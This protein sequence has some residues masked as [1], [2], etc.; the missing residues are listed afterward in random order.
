MQTTPKTA[1][2]APTKRANRNRI[3][4]I[5]RILFQKLSQ[6]DERA[7][8]LNTCARAHPD[9]FGGTY[10][11]EL[12]QV[13]ALDDPVAPGNAYAVQRIAELRYQLLL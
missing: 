11:R 4:G 6:G 12:L 9:R 3:I 13:F 10:G 5:R 8:A 7:Q 2:N 1:T